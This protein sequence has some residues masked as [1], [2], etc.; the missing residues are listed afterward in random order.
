MYLLKQKDTGTVSLKCTRQYLSI[1]THIGIEQCCRATPLFPTQE[2]ISR[3]ESA[4]LGG[5]WPGREQF[6]LI[7]Q[8]TFSYLREQTNTLVL[9][10][11]S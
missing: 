3:F 5:V 6:Y 4:T 10:E 7:K 2:M 8:Q 1:T 11:V 9:L